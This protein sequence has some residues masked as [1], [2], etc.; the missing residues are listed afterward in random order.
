MIEDERL[1]W[2]FKSGSAGALQR[3]YEKYRDYLLTLAMALVNDAP[4]AEDIVQDVFV[5]FAQSN[6]TFKLRGSLKSYLATCTLNRCRDQIRARKRRPLS[7]DEDKPMQSGF[8]P[9]D[10]RMIADERSRQV[11]GAMAQLPYEQREVVALHLNAS[12]K[13][14]HIAGLQNVSV[15]TVKGRYRYGLQKLR[16]ALNG[17]L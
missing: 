2:K 12:M 17:K 15:S 11:A 3:I 1:K 14:R 8:D 6:G 5:V 10:K 7:L 4:L 9:P 16:A 13:L